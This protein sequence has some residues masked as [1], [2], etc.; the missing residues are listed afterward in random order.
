ML[1]RSRGWRSA[2]FALAASSLPAADESAVVVA[3]QVKGT[4]EVLRGHSGATESVADGTQ[5]AAA[6]TV[7]TAARSSVMLV[8]PNGSIVALKEKS[9]LKIAVAL[10][11]GP[12]FIAAADTAGTAETGVSKIEL[13]LEFG[14]L[15]TRV[16]KLNPGSVLNV[17]TPISMAAVRGTV[18][19]LVYQPEAPGGASFRLS[20]ASGLVHVTPNAGREIPVPANQQLDVTADLDARGIRIKQVKTSKLDQQRSES[21]QREAQDN[22]RSAAELLQ[23][24][25]ATRTDSQNRADDQMKERAAAT[26]A[27]REEV[28]AAAANRAKANASQSGSTNRVTRPPATKTPPRVNP[29]QRPPRRPGG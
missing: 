1:L 21:L 19:E 17:R 25:P 24:L 29:N 20:T 9:R 13:D 16:R 12:A 15:L 14:E 26:G 23:R 28:N 8:L 11:S 2:L 3:V 10:R 22:D 18:F 5:L 6:D 27:T 4:V 7:T